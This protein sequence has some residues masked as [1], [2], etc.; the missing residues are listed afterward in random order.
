MRDEH[1]SVTPT[2]VHALLKV[3][4]ADKL[5]KISS[6]PI[7]P[8]GPSDLWGKYKVV[9]PSLPQQFLTNVPV[10]G[11]PDKIDL[12]DKEGFAGKSKAILEVTADDLP[13]GEVHSRRVRFELPDDIKPGPGSEDIK[14][15]FKL[16]EANTLP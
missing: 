11:P 5:G 1:V 4:Q 6:M 7:F 12:L 2:T 8:A 10:I 3:R 14:V 16:V 13:A 15:D 9:F